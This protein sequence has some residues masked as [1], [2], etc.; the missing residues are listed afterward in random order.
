VHLSGIKPSIQTGLPA[1]VKVCETMTRSTMPFPQ[2]GQRVSASLASFRPLDGLSLV[3]TDQYTHLP[4]RRAGAA[5]AT[6]SFAAR[7]PHAGPAVLEPFE[8]AGGDRPALGGV[9]LLL[10]ARRAGVPAVL[11]A[12]APAASRAGESHATGRLP[13]SLDSSPVARLRAACPHFPQ[14]DELRPL[15]AASAPRGA[16]CRPD[17]ILMKG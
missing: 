9:P 17:G 10:E 6:S 1:T 16:G 15:R 12:F 8:L 4:G 2:A 5:L 14:P 7:S 13:P 11:L 3:L